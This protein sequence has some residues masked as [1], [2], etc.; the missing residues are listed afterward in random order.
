MKKNFF[1]ALLVSLILP[2]CAHALPLSS[3]DIAG[4]IHNC[5]SF[6]EYKTD[7]GVIWNRKLL[8]T[9]GDDGSMVR[10]TSYV[11]LCRADARLGWLENRLYAPAGGHIELEQAAYFDP[12][13]GDFKGSIPYYIDDLK[14]EGHL[15]FAWPEMKDN[16]VLVLS[17]RQ[18]FPESSGFEDL[19]WLGSEYPVWEGS[20]QARI[21][22]DKELLYTSADDGDPVMDEDGAFRRYGWFYFKQPAIHGTAGML[23]TSDPYVAFSLEI[24]PAT[25]IGMMN[26]LSSRKWPSMPHAAET[27]LKT[28]D[29]VLAAIDNFWTSGYRIPGRGIWRSPEMIPVSGPW[30]TWES[31]YLVASWLKDMGWDAEVWFRHVLP[32]GKESLSCVRGFSHPVLQLKAPGE[33]KS[34]FYIPGQPVTPG[35]MPIALRGKTLYTAGTDKKGNAILRRRPVGAL[36]MSKNRLTV[37]WDLDIKKDGAVSGEL[38]VLVRNSW[39]DMFDALTE[40]GSDIIYSLLPGI[41]DWVRPGTKARITPLGSRGFKIAM[42]VRSLSGI[43]APQGLMVT[44]PSVIPGPMI[45]LTSLQGA[46]V[47]KFPFVTEQNYTIQLPSGYRMMSLPMRIDHSGGFYTTYS[48]RYHMNYRKN[49]LSGGEKLIQGDIHIDA[50]FVDGFKQMLAMWGTW[51][52]KDMALVPSK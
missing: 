20:I 26:N 43:P 18:Y 5:P 30:T 50:P 24:G 27:P 37:N 2:V 45:K 13:T 15:K 21:P 7:S 31:V 19:V 16:Y 49:V 6:E 40:G 14:K 8:Y 33:R 12:A 46:A 38:E 9:T 28:R 25:A 42:P 11:I 34:W 4:M 1:F 32:Q 41:E 35:K 39:V 44:L 22:V 48:S 52:G 17:Y 51:R 23:E 36:K 10:H 47:L 3:A 29:Q